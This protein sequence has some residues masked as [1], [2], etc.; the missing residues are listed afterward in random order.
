MAVGLSVLGHWSAGATHLTLLIFVPL[1]LALLLW[2]ALLVVFVGV[3]WSRGGR[4]LPLLAGLLLTVVAACAL[5][6]AVLGVPRRKVAAAPA[7]A[8]FERWRA[9]HGRYP[10]VDSG[11]RAFPA[12]L[13]NAIEGAGCSRY[14]A[15]DESF[16]LSCAGYDYRSA[17]QRWSAWD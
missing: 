8:A 12:E 15:W 3:R 17:T 14:V 16:L 10:R 13:R 5:G 11:D 7:L 9:E 6:D 2:G 4:V 1:A